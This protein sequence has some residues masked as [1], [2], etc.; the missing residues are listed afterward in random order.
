MN[1]FWVF[2]NPDFKKGKKKNPCSV[3]I[4]FQGCQIG[5]DIPAQSGNPGCQ[6]E[7]ENLAQSGNPANVSVFMPLAISSAPAVWFRESKV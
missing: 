2:F 4:V 6:I 3:Q 7:R 1:V 5:P